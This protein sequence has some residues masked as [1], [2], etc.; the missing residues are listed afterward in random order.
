MPKERYYFNANFKIGDIITITG[1]EFMHMTKVMRAQRND[2]VDIINGKNT[3][4]N[5]K[6]L[7]IFPTKIELEIVSVLTPTKSLPKIILH[8]SLIKPAK[9]DWLIE[10]V[11]ELGITEVHLYPSL[12]SEKASPSE[13]RHDRFCSI[14]KAAAKQCGRLDFPKI[15]HRSDLFSY[16]KT[17]GSYFFGDMRRSSQYLI[18]TLSKGITFP[19][20]LFIGPEKGFSPK[21][22]RFLE[23]DLDAKGIRLN[24]NILRSETAAISG[25]NIISHLISTV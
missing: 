4:A 16:T 13:N 21:E 7:N 22:V 12:N 3:L 17:P 19:L 5:G 6:V 24:E 2:I 11:T 8:Q 15:V 1:S 9:L 10:K 20:H 14:I 23:K 25:I 18:N